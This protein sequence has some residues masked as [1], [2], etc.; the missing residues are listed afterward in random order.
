MQELKAG[1]KFVGVHNEQK[2]AVIRATEKL[3]NVTYVTYL[4]IF[5]GSYSSSKTIVTSE[6][7]TFLYEYKE[8]EDFFVVG[9]QYTSG[10]LTYYVQ[11]LYTISSPINSNYRT[12]ARA[13]IIDS[14]GKRWMEMLNATDYSYV[15]RVK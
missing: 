5:T 1:Q 10:R 11:E 7:D 2:S 12:Q 14:V 9:G 3:G 13:I 4:R 8:K 15:K 6:A